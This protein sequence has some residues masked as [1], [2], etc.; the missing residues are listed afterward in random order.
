M[1]A[2]IIRHTVLVYRAHHIRPLSHVVGEQ[3]LKI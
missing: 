3:A 1:L 2:L